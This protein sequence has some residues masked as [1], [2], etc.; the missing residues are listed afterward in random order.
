MVRARW[1]SVVGM[2]ALVLPGGLASGQL[3]PPDPPAPPAPPLQAWMF[4]GE[5]AAEQGP[6]L[7]VQLTPVPA[8]VAYQLQ[9]DKEAG[10]MVRNVFKD[11]PADRAGIER[12]DVIVSADGEKVTGGVEAFSRLVRRHQPKESLRLEVIRKGQHATLEIPLEAAPPAGD[13]PEM[14]Y[15]DDDPDVARFRN[16]GLRG[17]IL[18]MNPGGEW[19]LEDLGELPEFGSRLWSTPSRKDAPGRTDEGRRVQKDGTVLHVTRQKDGSIKVQRTRPQEDGASRQVAIYPNAEELKKADGE[20]F[21]LLQEMDRPGALPRM[22]PLPRDEAWREWRE[23]FFQGPLKAPRMPAA[24]RMPGR[25][26]KPGQPPV[27]PSPP[28]PPVPPQGEMG[29]PP[30]AERLPGPPP[31]RFEVDEN[32]RVTVH[33]RKPDAEMTMV[34]KSKDALRERA[35]ELF[36]QFEDMEHQMR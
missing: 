31:M 7:G 28:S 36:K 17:K 19:I 13:E 24:P 18:R 9:L 14:K 5:V 11:S 34:F 23:R 30:P 26:A 3:Q 4:A 2:A 27:P 33:L 1:V 29:G 25:P 20:A 8:A 32:G 35:P 12:Y 15:P 6:W 21:D 10:L 22:G 16:F